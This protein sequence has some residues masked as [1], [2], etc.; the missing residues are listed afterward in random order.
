MNDSQKHLLIGLAVGGVIVLAY[1]KMNPPVTAIAVPSAPT[2][3]PTSAAHATSTTSDYGTPIIVANNGQ[4]NT[5][6]GVISPA[7]L[8]YAHFNTLIADPNKVLAAYQPSDIAIEN[9]RATQFLN[10]IGWLDIY[11]QYEQEEPS[12]SENDIIMFCL[13]LGAGFR[14]FPPAS[15]MIPYALPAG[16][17]S[18]GMA[19]SAPNGTSVNPNG[20][21]QG[22][23]YN[24]FS[25]VPTA[26]L[27]AYQKAYGTATTA[28]P[29]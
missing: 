16:Y 4:L 18:T 23:A 21:M 12:P 15:A 5:V 10:E 27:A 3:T 29:Q 13:N 8:T 11:E 2:P 28:T 20:L 6:V 26:T 7:Q 17:V 22:I 25:Y 19:T 9:T 24:G 1:F 14:L